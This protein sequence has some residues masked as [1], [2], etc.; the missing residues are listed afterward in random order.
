[1][2]KKVRYALT[3]EKLDGLFPDA[4]TELHY[5]NPFQLLVAVILSAQCTDKRV[6]MITPELFKRFPTSA[7]MAKASEE[8]I[9]RYIKS[10]S[11]PNAK[12][13][14]LLKMAQ[15][16][17]EVYKDELPEE[18]KDLESL[19]GVG[20]K[21]ANVIAAVLYKQA[22]MPVDT[23]VHR[24]SRRI[25]LTTGAKTP[26]ETEKQLMANLDKTS[27]IALLHHQLILLGRYICKARKPECEACPLPDCCKFY[28]TKTKPE[29]SNRRYSTS[30]KK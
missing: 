1:M 8:E 15:R 21:T 20:R 30:K 4:Q 16:L 13:K 22:V 2:R 29:N 18:R 28:A 24:V 23:H 9:Y 6:N 26:L 17:H 25:G 12:S 19:A 27:D 14:N 7:E 5:D 10:I 11:Y 3:I